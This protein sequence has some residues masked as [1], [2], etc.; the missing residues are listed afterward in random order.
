MTI[1]LTASSALAVILKFGGFDIYRV[2]KIVGEGFSFDELRVIALHAVEQ[3]SCE[4]KII[5][6]CADAR[7]GNVVDVLLLNGDGVLELSC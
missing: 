1:S 4:R 6:P 7:L 5:L 3:I 2:I